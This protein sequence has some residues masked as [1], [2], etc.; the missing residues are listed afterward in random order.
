VSASEDIKKDLIRFLLGQVKD[1]QLSK[2]RALGFLKSLEGTDKVASSDVAVIGIAC[3]FPEADSKEEF[4]GN[5]DSGRLSIRPFPANRRADLAAIDNEQAELFC[6]GFLNNVD[7][8]DSAYFN[9]AP[10]IA[11]H[12]DPYHRLFLM[13]LIEAIEDAGYS[14]QELNGKNIGVFAG[15][16]HTHRLFNSYLD[17]VDEPG[18]NAITGSWTAIFASRLSYLLNLKGPAMVVDTSCSSGL[19]ALDCAIKALQAGDC[20]SALVGAAN[21]F[22]APG[23]GIVGDIEN[24]DFRVRAFDEK[25]TGT[26]WGEGV[27]ALM[28]KTLA[29][30]ER[31]GDT[32]YG[33]IK[34]IAVNND[35][36]SNGITAPNAKAQQDVVLKAWEKAGIDPEHISYIE[37]HGTGTN[38]GDPIE[39]KGLVGAFGRH[40]KRKQ[41][42]GLGSVKTNIGHTVGVAGLA[43]LIKVLLAMK[44]QR[45]PASLNFDV[46]NPFIDFC[47]SPI[48]INDHSRQWAAEGQRLAGVS[49]FSL[50]GTN[51]HLVVQEPEPSSRAVAAMDRVHLF[52][53]SARNETL[54]QQ[55]LQRYIQFIELDPSA[56]FTDICATAAIGREHHALRIAIACNSLAQLKDQLIALLNGLVQGKSLDQLTGLVNATI[57]QEKT[58]VLDKLAQSIT[59]SAKTGF[60]ITELEQLSLLYAAGAVINWP[61]LF[62]DTGWKRAHLPAQPFLLERHWDKAAGKVVEKGERENA[63]ADIKKDLDLQQI[64]SLLD[65]KSQIFIGIPTNATTEVI[66]YKLTAYVIAESLGYA[67]LKW[68]DDFYA[69]GGDS[70]SAA[71]IIHILN[72]LCL[73]SVSIADLLAA[74]SLGGFSQKLVEVYHLPE[75]IRAAINSSPGDNQIQPIEH[76]DV[77][78]LSSA[79]KRM[80]LLSQITPEST[81]YNVNS[82]IAM[83]SLPDIDQTNILVQALIERHEIL[84]TGFEMIGSEPM[85]RV[86]GNVIFNTDVYDLSDCTQGDIQKQIDTVIKSFIRPFDLTNPPLLRLG[87]ILAP[88]DHYYMLI[89]MHHIVTDGSSMG[90]LISDYLHLLAGNTLPPL[91]FQYKDFAVWHNRHVI[92]DDYRR[93]ALYWRNRF[94]DGI[95][96]CELSADFPRPV[97]QQFSGQKIH[98]QLTAEL[99]EKLKKLAAAHSVSLFVLLM[100]ALRVLLFKYR[101][102][103]DLVI[104]SP[105]TGRNQVALHSL[106][107]M[108]V[109]TLALRAEVKPQ[110]SFAHFLK[111][112][113]QTTLEDLAHQDYPYEDLVESL[114]IPRNPGRNPLFDIYFVL[115]NT[116]MGLGAD[117]GLRTLDVDTG[118]AK[119][120]L[121]IIAREAHGSLAIEWEFATA[122]FA[123]DTIGKMTSHFSQLLESICN[124]VDSTITALDFLST[125]ERKFLL[126]DI[127]QTDTDYPKDHGISSLFEQQVDL[128]PDSI[129]V[130]Q[131]SQQLTYAQLNDRAN[132]LAHYLVGRGISSGEF[133]ALYFTPSADMVTAILAVL[134]IG[135]AYVPLDPENPVER[136]KGILHD[137]ATSWLLSVSSLSIPNDWPMQSL[138]IDTLDLRPYPTS[139]PDIAISGDDLIYAMYTSGTTGRPKGTLLRQKSIIRVVCNT[140]FLSLDENDVC[141][142]LS[143]YAFDGCVLDLYGALL[144]G[145][146]LVLINKAE[147]FD[148][149]ALG[150][151]IQHQGITSL[152][153]TTSL[154]N[155]LVD[156][157][158]NCL[159]GVRQI[160]FGGE[161]ASSK[162]INK[163]YA[164]LGP[165]R[166]IN[167]YGPTETAV[168]ATT[169]S[170]QQPPALHMA[171]AIGSPIANTHVYVLDEQLQPVPVG[172]VGELYIG[173]DGVAVGYL[174]QPE[175]TAEK[176]IKNPFITNDRLYKTGDLVKWLPDNNIQYIGRA[177]HQLK[178][179]GFR[180]ELEEIREVILQASGVM[181]CL[182]IVDSQQEGHKQLLAYIVVEDPDCFNTDALRQQL[183]RQLP[184][185]MLPS[186]IIALAAFPLTNNGKVDRNKLPEP[187]RQQIRRVAPTNLAETVLAQ[188]WQAVLGLTDI[189]TTENFFSL[190][191]DSI[192]GIQVI[193]NLQNAG[194]QLQMAQLFQY[195]T[196]SELAPWLTPV[197]TNTAGQ[198][199][200]TGALPLN[201]IQRW[202]FATQQD[203]LDHF[204]QSMFIAMENIPERAQLEQALI[205]LCTHHDAL[206]SRFYRDNDN[207]CGEITDNLNNF[208]LVEWQEK[209]WHW[210]SESLT[211]R[212]AELQMSLSIE[213][214]ILLTLGAFRSPLQQGVC[215]A[216]HHLAVDVI[217]W[218][219]LLQD[220]QICLD[221]ATHKQTPV[222]VPK[223]HSIIEWNNALTTIANQDSTLASLDYW[224]SI[225]QA[226]VRPICINAPVGYV[227]GAHTLNHQ[228][229]AGL[230]SDIM[231]AANDAFHTEPQHL[232]L[233]AL[234]VALETWKGS[235]DSLIQL[236]RHGRDALPVRTQALDINRTCGW[237]TVAFPF[238]LTASADFSQ[239]IKSVKESLRSLPGKGRDYG[240][241]TYLCEKLGT[242]ERHILQQ[243]QPTIG[244]NFLGSVDTGASST[245]QVIPLGRQLTSSAQMRQHLALDLVVS[246]TRS[247]LELEVLFDSSRLNEHEVN[248][249][250]MV[251][252]KALEDIT[253]YCLQREVT[254]KTASDFTATDIKQNELDA[255]FED[256]DIF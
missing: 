149:N 135:C 147:I 207:W 211:T 1:K 157:R 125:Q 169:L 124:H 94:S 34:G 105:V 158:L 5:L 206:R 220:L 238:L 151:I 252:A 12:M 104:G 182:V 194:W 9:I 200:V 2:D 32:I 148:L 76:A 126:H 51:C 159:A 112:L 46:P 163:A 143:S 37:S 93:Q 49:S 161:A 81:A 245:Q 181:E 204:N 33:V 115:Q 142:L 178:I 160:M 136:N 58:A 17:F 117:G 38:L 175:L 73:T 91:P 241:L 3:H 146:R 246:V 8:F 22:F 195:Q 198:G 114:N 224:L 129:A 77:Y 107:G 237:F 192:R 145:G 239:V 170:V 248:E 171:V 48:F 66:A 251:F 103:A 40:T 42:C 212:L 30:A 229:A 152:F 44:Y 7:G 100:A 222:L 185:Y 28:V 132:S 61:L 36:A 74:E 162:H 23:K 139:N 189:G 63:N 18:F 35:G 24:D 13:T 82:V 216:I 59:D 214:G 50:S 67:Q 223:T 47:S 65:E 240:L 202:F 72:E 203:G 168:F 242:K 137:C 108:F 60:D 190:G 53:L 101:A 215:I 6:G 15:N 64:V 184:D 167:G 43:S 116:D 25:A 174:N 209:D 54:L 187:E 201:P 247:Q 80:Y 89:D 4:W 213:K 52:P 121:T 172:V 31:D 156:N 234:A 130:Q 210:G 205:H 225:A 235:G 183:A 120:D 62:V 78:T 83:D 154:F 86:H 110:K 57:A 180:I 217:S 155:V 179:R 109:N 250:L 88:Q 153:A 98:Q 166:L 254:E 177:D 111:S 197:V 140:N 119:F 196:I 144:N 188:A 228:L 165:G 186:S 127:N 39:I 97:M 233:A 191:G 243:L 208:I 26:A 84:R 102:G 69:L 85:Q 122:L 230:S 244:F 55:T 193:A 176:F 71:R 70:I 173:G 75:K 41:F 131:G 133:I 199:L 123:A 164:Q 79:Q 19:V 231:G 95:P 11:R 90:I 249:F 106:I 29:A 20:E 113:K 219:V 128:R 141:L 226:D 27:A 14:R 236:E 256:L 118:I 134:K 255:I 68:Q 16:D 45:L 221:A 56:N 96:V 10:A 253:H 92:S 227:G 21:L 232:I 138:A 150:N 99:T 218:N 87:F